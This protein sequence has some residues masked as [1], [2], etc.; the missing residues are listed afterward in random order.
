MTECPDCEPFPDRKWIYE[1]IVERIP[2]F[3]WL[4]PTWDVIAQLFLVEAV[5]IA[6]FFIFQMPFETVIIGSLTILYTVVWSAGCLYVIP[7]LRRLQNPTNI[8]E[9]SV[10]RSYK[11]RLLLDRKYELG[12]G[13]AF[14][15]G[16]MGYLFW[17]PSLL[18]HFLGPNYS[19][20]LLLVLIAILAWDVS[21]RMALSFITTLFAA[22]RSIGLAVA[23]RR[24]RGLEYTAYSEVRTLKFLD[25]VNLYWAASAVLLFPVAIQSEIL[26]FG[27]I[28][29]LGAILGLS[30]ISLM[31][32]ETVPWF[33]PDVESILHIERFAYVAACEKNQPHVTPVIFVYD[34]KYFY[35]A[36]SLASQKYKIIRKNS[37]VAA[38]VDMRDSKNPMNNRAIQIRG[39]AT[40]LGEVSAF[41]IVK[42][43]LY[44]FWLLRARSLFA[45][46]YPRYMKYYDDQEQ[47]LPLAWQNK[48][49]ISRVLVR[50]EP[51]NIT[52]WRRA[53]PVVLR[54]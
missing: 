16:V 1:D 18:I 44:G 52:F 23:A 48:P 43:F 26:I 20:P 36:I 14:F 42:L 27:L 35:F 47:E 12:G 22:S 51:E 29:F 31:A 38:L 54:A 34:G 30:L 49:F 40:I 46:K 5:G 4:P 2:P 3:R 39:K 53:K 33:P 13:I 11:R 32:M 50:L 25:S 37:K 7:W 41:G 19:N 10:L 6:A 17:D 9:L 21:Y 15:A 24:R 45:K 8:E 28:A